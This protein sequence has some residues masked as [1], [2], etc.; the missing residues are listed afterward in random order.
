M[1]KH[2]DLSADAI[3]KNE[4]KPRVEKKQVKKPRV[5]AAMRELHAQRRSELAQARSDREE[6]DELRAFV[7][8]KL[9]KHRVKERDK[10]TKVEDS[11]EEGE[12]YAYQK[13]A[14]QTKLKGVKE[15]LDQHIQP[16][17]SHLQQVEQRLHHM[18]QRA[19]NPYLAMLQNRR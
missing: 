7:R 1:N 2:M 17:L 4:A 8:V 10:T 15:D 9:E 18:H 3:E 13:K 11:D 6:L 19:Q 12:S 5:A 14:K 16:V